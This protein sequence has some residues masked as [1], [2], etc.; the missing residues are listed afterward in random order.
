MTDLE[1]ALKA[2]GYER[3]EIQ[4]VILELRELMEHG[5]DVEEALRS[6][7]GLEPDYLMDLMDY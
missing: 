4:E 3:A 1:K 5:E 7:Y 6:D 2:Q